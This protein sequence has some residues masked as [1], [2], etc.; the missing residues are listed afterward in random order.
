MALFHGVNLDELLKI[1]VTRCRRFLVNADRTG[2]NRHRA[3]QKYPRRWIALSKDCQ[4]YDNPYSESV[5]ALSFHMAPA[6]VT[7]DG[8]RGS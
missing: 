5:R 4:T 8:T 7:A 2:E 6:P 3:V 1:K